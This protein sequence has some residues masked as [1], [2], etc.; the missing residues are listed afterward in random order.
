MNMLTGDWTCAIGNVNCV[1]GVASLAD[2]MTEGVFLSNIM[3]LMLKLEAM[4]AYLD[5]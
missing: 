3:S 1:L 4:P 5:S 2:V